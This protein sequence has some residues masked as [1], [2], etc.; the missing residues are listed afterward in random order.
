MPGA[1]HHYVVDCSHL[2]TAIH[3]LS[4]ERPH[5]A[6][7]GRVGVQ[8]GRVGVVAKREHFFEPGCGW[9]SSAHLRTRERRVTRTGD[10]RP[11]YR[12]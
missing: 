7:S 12:S 4:H 2:V 5:L 11:G 6:M 8:H 1:P 3:H 10:A 9:H